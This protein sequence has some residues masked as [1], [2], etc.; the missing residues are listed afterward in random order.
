MNKKIL[1][2]IILQAVVIVTLAWALVF[3][4]K[5]EYEV[6]QQSDN[7]EISSP[8][9]VSEENGATVVT[10]T[11]ASQKASGI[12]TTTLQSASHQNEL[13]SYGSVVGIEPLTDLRAKYQAALADANV[14][15]A[16][17]N[18][19]QQDYQRLKALNGDNKNI[20]DRAVQ[21]AEAAWKADQARLAAAETQAAGIRDNMRQQWG[22]I[23]AGGGGGVESLQTHQQVLVQVALP[24]DVQ[25]ANIN[26]ISIAAT[27][28]RGK[29]IPATYIGPSPQTDP[30][31][32]GRTYFFRA[33]SQDLRAGMRVE[34]HVQMQGTARQGVTIP[35]D[36]VVWYLGKAWAYRKEGAEKFVRQ[37]VNTDLTADN[38]WF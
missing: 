17:I 26:R 2:I 27:G 8:S 5:D 13:L 23:L 15:R 10:L 36:A 29:P 6:A 14:V 31:M 11:V 25:P 38:G 16:S 24:D 34:A 35:T 18:N 19:T 30:T 7:K 32:Q 33:S 22:D 20:S 12:M 37:L 9:R 4:G 21:V 28:G 1:A 3:Y